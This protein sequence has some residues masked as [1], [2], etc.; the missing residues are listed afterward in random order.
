MS[1]TGMIFLRTGG[2]KGTPTNTTHQEHSQ[3]S[4]GNSP[5]C[6]QSAAWQYGRRQQLHLFLSSKI[7]SF[8]L[9]R[10]GSESGQNYSQLNPLKINQAEAATEHAHSMV[11]SFTSFIHYQSPSWWMIIWENYTAQHAAED[12]T[13]LYSTVEFGGDV[14]LRMIKSRMWSAYSTT[15]TIVLV[16]D[17]LVQ[18]LFFHR[19]VLHMFL[20][21]DCSSL[22]FLVQFHF[23][24]SQFSFLLPAATGMPK[25]YHLYLYVVWQNKQAVGMV[26]WFSIKQNLIHTN[27]TNH[28]TRKAGEGQSKWVSLALRK[29]CEGLRSREDYWSTFAESTALIFSHRP[30]CLSKVLQIY[31]IFGVYVVFPFFLNVLNSYLSEIFL[32][33]VDWIVGCSQICHHCYGCYPAIGLRGC[34]WWVFLPKVI[35]FKLISVSCV[36]KFSEIVGQMARF[37][38]PFNGLRQ[39]GFCLQKQ[40]MF[41]LYL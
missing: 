8:D 6:Q 22:F 33:T 31:L 35:N 24:L 37:W 19:V 11:S 27:L 29:T 1:W 13:V 5:L 18:I 7:H 32:N 10:D 12:E 38:T 14:I 3:S 16:G 34:C 2:I 20:P 41:G 4:V 21:Y 28:V 15:D 30:L 9:T 25:F 36:K 23:Y 17:P 26:G 40:V 39:I